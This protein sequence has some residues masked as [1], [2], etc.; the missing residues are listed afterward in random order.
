MAIQ[1]QAANV[2][3]LPQDQAVSPDV[4]VETLLGGAGI[5]EGS[6][7]L[8]G[9]E[10]M[11]VVQNGTLCIVPA[12]TFQTGGS[13]VPSNRGSVTVSGA[14]T[15]IT[16][17]GLG[18]VVVHGKATGGTTTID[19]NGGAVGQMLRVE[20]VQGATVEVVLLGTS[21][22]IGAIGSFTATPTIGIRDIMLFDNVD[23]SN[24]ALVAIS[25]GF[26]V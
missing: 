1:K 8:A 13:Y 26:V 22:A 18:S 3:F 15:A 2:Q 5:P 7:P 24:W 20:H 19:I 4:I 12:S 6:V 16:A 17:T 23:G 10:L 11:Y 25:Q 21:V 14:N 9:S